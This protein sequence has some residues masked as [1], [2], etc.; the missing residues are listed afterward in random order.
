MMSSN[1]LTITDPAQL[2]PG[3]T[4][5]RVKDM[6]PPDDHTRHITILTVYRDVKPNE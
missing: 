1:I 6:Q 2:Q 5:I 3:D 4:I